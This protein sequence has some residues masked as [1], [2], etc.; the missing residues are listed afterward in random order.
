MGESKQDK[1]KEAEEEILE[2]AEDLI[3][4][5]GEETLSEESDQN[6][7]E[8][9]IAKLQDENKEQLER[10]LRIQAEF[11]N[12]KRRTQ[13]E[14]ANERKYQVQK[15]AEELL[16]V[17]DNFE[18]ALKVEVNEESKGIYEGIQMVY[19]Q[20]LEA[21]KSQG[22]EAIDVEKEQ[23]DPNLHHAVMQ[24]EDDQ[25]QPNE[26]VEELQKGYMLNDRVLRP[27]M[28]KVNK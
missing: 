8:D 4:D 26:I 12:Y 3:L 16:P 19:K 24:V 28:V 7:E 23:F 21:L 13:Q 20:F 5:E 14:R 10:M 11:D 2:Q 25:Y 22:V 1:T 6:D 27:S 9:T 18:R 17:L 15:L